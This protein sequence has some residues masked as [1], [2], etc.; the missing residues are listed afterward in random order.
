MLPLT[1]DLL[2]VLQP[3]IAKKQSDD[4]V[5]LSFSGGAID[6]RM[7][8]RR[9]FKPVLKGLGITD[10]DLYACRHTFGS[11][12]IDQGITPVMTAFLMG[13]NPETAL[14]NYTHQITLPQD[15]PSI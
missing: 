6:D 8:Q 12:C 2:N 11:R 1:D 15:L 7:F 4:L 9:V 3:L 13:N 14:R 10:R 5:F